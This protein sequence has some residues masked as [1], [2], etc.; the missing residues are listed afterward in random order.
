MDKI[1]EVLSKQILLIKLT[2]EEERIIEKQTEEVIAELKKQIKRRKIKA[3]VFIGGSL[4][5]DT[6]IKKKMYDIDIF[7]RFDKK[8]KNISVLLGKIVKK[9]KKVHGSRDYFQIKKGNVIFELIPV[10]K[11]Q[12]PEQAENVTDLSYFHVKYIKGKIKKNKR[13]GD[14][15]RLVKTFCYAQ[16]CY[17]AESYISGF[18]GYA[19]ELLVSHYGSFI[20]FVKAASKKN[21]MILDPN[22]FYK[23]KQ[24][25]L[26][27]LNESKLQSPIVFVD[28]TF[29]E[30]NALAA[31]SK[32]T[33]N[34]FKQACNKFL[35]S[36]NNISFEKRNIEQ[37]LR[38]KYKDL[39]IIEAGTSKQKGAIAGSK[40]KKFHGFLTRKVEKHFDIKMKEFEYVEERNI[41]KIYLSLKQKKQIIIAGPPITSVENLVKFKKK[42]K[43]C[44]IKKGRAYAYEQ[45]AS[46]KKLLDGLKQDKT[47]KEMGITNIN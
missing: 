13:L 32:S 4:A 42:H 10:L 16:D 33:F 12:K 39:I 40:L 14:N 23:N 5:K 25:V 3:D 20:K 44:I 45:P 41:G 31:L 47:V 11:I 36:P 2:E 38:K 27:E 26:L 19:L 46:L 24:E 21:R 43:K 22:K 17:G 18:S 34:K 6:L 9:A 28:P 8:H 1:K 35:N 29:K 37:E 15:I 7:V 30:R